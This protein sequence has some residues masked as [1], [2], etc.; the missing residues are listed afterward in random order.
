LKGASVQSIDRLKLWNVLQPQTDAGL[1]CEGPRLALLSCQSL[2]MQCPSLQ[3]AL[4]ASHPSLVAWLGRSD[5]RLAEVS[6]GCLPEWSVLHS[7]AR[8]HVAFILLLCCWC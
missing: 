1:L 2:G 7:L 8:G 4:G 6:L 3:R 5:L